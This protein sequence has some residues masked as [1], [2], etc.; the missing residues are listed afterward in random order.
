MT[1]VQNQ[2]IRIPE[3]IGYITEQIANYC[4]K[5]LSLTVCSVANWC[6]FVHVLFS[7]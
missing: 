1:F 6:K 5:G 2:V 7:T 4:Y 3:N